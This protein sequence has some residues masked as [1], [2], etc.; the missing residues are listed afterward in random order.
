MEP[1]LTEPLESTESLSDWKPCKIKLGISFAVN[2]C[3][4][5]TQGYVLIPRW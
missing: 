3:A 1:K 5:L 2:K 4:A